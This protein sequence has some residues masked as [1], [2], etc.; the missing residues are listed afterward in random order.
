[1]DLAYDRF[2]EEEDFRA[3]NIL[4]PILCDSESFNLLAGETEKMGATVMSQG[5]GSISPFAKQ[6]FTIKD[7]KNDKLRNILKNYS[8]PD[9]KKLLNSVC[10]HLLET[11]WGKRA[12]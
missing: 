4:K 9:P 12:T 5:L 6:L 1:L 3:R 11:R 10:S 2:N 8:A 7:I